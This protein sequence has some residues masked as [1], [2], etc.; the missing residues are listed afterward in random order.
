M[1]DRQ[2]LAVIFGGRS[3]EHEVSVTSARGIMRE[4]DPERFEVIPFAI[5]KRGAWLTPEETRSRLER[6]D[7]GDRRDI[8]DDKGE[9]FL[10]YP[11]VVA[12]LSGADVVFPIVHG[13]F[14]EDGTMQGLL[15]M[16][17][18]PYVG[19]GVGASAAGLDKAMMRALFAAHGIPQARYVVFSDDEL[20]DGDGNVLGLID[21]E[22]G[23][24][25]FVKPANGGSSV[26]VGKARSREDIGAALAEAARFDRKVLVEEALEGQEVE[27]AVLGNRDPQ[28]SPLGEI[29][30]TTEFYDY[31]AK[32]LDDSAELIVPARIDD[33]TA[34][35][36]Q[37]LAVRAFRA[38]DCAGMSRVDFFVEPSGDIK[39]IEVNTLPGF[40]PISMYPRLWQ[41]AG[42]SYRDLITQ[43]VELAFE[44]HEEV[45]SHA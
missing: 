6:V 33:A 12:A 1:S 13:T 42:V 32:Y 21:A 41:E 16:A 24:P 37:E 39:C 45:R 44:R 15:E 20:H 38:L 9:G 35:R 26:G 3:A 17:D 11:D 14:G 43:L 34:V 27:C 18:L 19:P 5:T 4:A 2:R 28:A 22:I 7:R 30:P 8:G 40:T 29:R 36:V 31:T 25:C 10:A 23:Y